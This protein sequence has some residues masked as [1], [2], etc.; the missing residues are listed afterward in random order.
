MLELCELIKVSNVSA[1]VKWRLKDHWS[2][3][4][5]LIKATGRIKQQYSLCML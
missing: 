4:E 5:Q 1:I 2:T 3:V